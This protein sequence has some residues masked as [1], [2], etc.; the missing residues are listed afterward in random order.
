MRCKERFLKHTLSLCPTLNP[1]VA[2]SIAQISENHNYNMKGSHNSLT[3]ASPKKWWGWLA[4]PVWKCQRLNLS[5]QINAGVRCFDIRCAW[6][7]H[8]FIGAHGL[9]DLKIDIITA[10]R[11]IAYLSDDKAYIRIIL[12][13]GGDNPQICELF[14]E[15]C[16]HWQKLWPGMTFF[17]GR[18]K[19]T[20]AKVANVPDGPDV[21][22][23]IGSMK[24][25][26]GEI[27]PGLWAIMHRKDIP[28][29]YYNNKLPIVHID[30]VK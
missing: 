4:V 10:L 30:F 25:R 20:W 6:D 28:A 26:W 13:K 3:Y 24:S 15:E 29:E 2:T 1:A 11:F 5:Q 27:F 17:C 18:S 12:E 19:K 21:I 7:G 9:I 22:Q 14:K 16:K 8:K 23:H